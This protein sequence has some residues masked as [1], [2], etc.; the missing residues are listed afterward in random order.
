MWDWDSQ[1]N[2]VECVWEC[3]GHTQSIEC[4]AVEPNGSRFITG[5]WDNMLKI[6]HA[7]T[8]NNTLYIAF[9]VIKNEGG[10]G[11]KDKTIYNFFFYSGG[12]GRGEINNFKGETRQ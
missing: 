2:S 6:W 12:K 1:N 10:H 11:E 7:G 3:R 5:S 9:G 8:S 4:V